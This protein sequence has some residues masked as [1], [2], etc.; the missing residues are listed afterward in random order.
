MDFFEDLGK[1]I[2]DTAETIGKKTEGV[3]E[4]QRIKSQ[5]HAIEKS[6][7]KIMMDLG[8]MIYKRYEAGESV[9][10]EYWA[11]CDEVQNR[12]SKI[13]EYKKELA[14]VKGLRECESCHAVLEEEALF[15]SKC[16]AKIRI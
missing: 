13:E 2:S 5:V 12:Y 1:K 11:I 4:S 7:E 8:Q 15:C 14:D 10:E 16:G 9:P 3:V 6:I